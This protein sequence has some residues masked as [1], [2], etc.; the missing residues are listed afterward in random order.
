M[1][2][3]VYGPRHT[4]RLLLKEWHRGN[5]DALEAC[6]RHDNDRAHCSACAKSFGETWQAYTERR[7][8]VRG[9]KLASQFCIFRRYLNSFDALSCEP[10]LLRRFEQHPDWPRLKVGLLACS[11]QSLLLPHEY[12]A[13]HKTAVLHYAS[14]DESFDYRR[15]FFPNSFRLLPRPIRSIA[16]AKQCA[17]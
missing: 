17:V 14:H 1:Q 9:K 10:W 6:A 8:G 5:A 3:I 15:C 11:M 13:E 12:E 2:S 16:C 7:D 4:R